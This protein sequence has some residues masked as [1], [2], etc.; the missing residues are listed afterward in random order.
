MGGSN[1]IYG[2]GM[3]ELGMTLSYGQLVMDAEIVRMIRRVL[4]GMAVN[5]ETLAYE[6]IKSVGAGGNYLDQMHTLEHMRTAQSR[7]R[8]IDR[9]MRGPW[10]E[11]GSKDLAQRCR[12]EA[13]QLFASHRPTPLPPA[14]GKKLQEII[15]AAEEE[16]L[17]RKG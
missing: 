10:E 17:P 16:L 12:E 4:A 2:M 13:R 3:L 8:M 6:V 15:A 1:I 5:Q 11:K 9:Q 14:V 7:S